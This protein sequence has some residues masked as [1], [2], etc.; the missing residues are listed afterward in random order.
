MKKESSDTS[1]TWLDHLCEI[2]QVYE[3]G[4]QVRDGLRGLAQSSKDKDYLVTGIPLAELIDRLKKFGRVDVV[5]KSFG[6]IK[7]TPPYPRDGA[8]VTYDIALPRQEYSTG[9]GHTEFAVEFDHTCSVEDDLVR[10]DFTINALARSVTTGKLIDP[11]GGQKDLTARL[12]R[13][14]SERAFLEDPLRM[15]RAIQFAARFAFAIEEKT[16]A[17]IRKHVLLIETISA[18]RVAEELNKLLLKTARPSSGFRLMHDVGILKI[19]LPE[20]EICVGVDQPGGYHAFEKATFYG[21]EKHGAKTAK[22]ILRRLRYST[23]LIDQTALLIDHHMFTTEVTDKGMRRLI[24]RMGP[25]LVFDLLNLR[26]ADVVAQGMG[27]TTEDVDE[28]EQRIRDELERKPPFGLSDLAINGTILMEQLNL[29]PGPRL[30]SML[31]HLLEQVL[32]DPA[33]NTRDQLLLIA[34]RYNARYDSE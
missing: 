32:D 10:R 2:G 26:R 15:L 33:L 17:A 23:E 31:N 7:F 1:A 13:F 24:R 19:I 28:L 22:T 14:I 34:A 3:V 5:G 30:G 11:T 29:Q 18:E 27:G 4:G 25:E 8:P 21:H 16:L 12:I 6:V 9:V 20:L